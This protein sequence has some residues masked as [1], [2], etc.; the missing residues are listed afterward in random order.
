MFRRSPDLLLIIAVTGFSTALVFAH[1]GNTFL[2]LL[3]AVPCVFL[4]PGYALMMAFFPTNAWGKAER[5]T[6]SLGLSLAV[7]ILGGLV[8]NWT[9]WGLSAEGWALWLGLGTM[10]VSIL[11]VWRRRAVPMVQPFRFRMPKVE[12]ALLA[13]AGLVFI[14]AVQVARLGALQQPVAGFTQLWLLPDDKMNPQAIRMGVNN[15]ENVPMHYRLCLQIDAQPVGAC[16]AIDLAVDERWETTAALPQSSEQARTVEAMLY[17]TDA[18]E[19]VYR[20]VA[21]WL[22]DQAE[23]E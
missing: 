6:F 4:F 19:T 8:L 21:L 3:L 10:G 13:F 15:M 9:P 23:E 14:A 12:E 20:R 18:P 2:R 16:T 22:D 17:R 7:S 1:A 11:A 5:I